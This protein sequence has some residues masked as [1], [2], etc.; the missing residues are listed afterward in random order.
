[1]GELARR[2]V[3]IS[4]VKS[5]L[6]VFVRLE[7]SVDTAQCYAALVHVLCVPIRLRGPHPLHAHE[8]PV[9][10]VPLPRTFTGGPSRMCLC[11][12]RYRRCLDPERA[13]GLESP[14]GGSNASWSLQ[15]IRAHGDDV[16]DTGRVD[17]RRVV[18]QLLLVRAGGDEDECGADTC[19]GHT[20]LP[21]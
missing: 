14:S 9:A 21:S 19:V 15:A 7:L 1:M 11:F 18:A 10:R 2:L 8:P 13:A 17:V 3:R 4:V 20:V 12:V 16:Q 6:E 5:A